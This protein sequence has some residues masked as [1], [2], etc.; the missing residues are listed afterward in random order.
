MNKLWYD[1]PLPFL[2]PAD[3]MQYLADSPYF[4]GYPSK[5]RDQMYEFSTT[6]KHL[7]KPRAMVCSFPVTDNQIDFGDWKYAMPP[8]K[9]Q[10]QEISFLVVALA[11][12]LEGYVE[13]L[14]KQNSWHAAMLD[15][16]AWQGLMEAATKLELEMI[17]Y[18]SPSTYLQL[19][20]HLDWAE[21]FIATYQKELS[22][23]MKT[24]LIEVTDESPRYTFWG[25]MGWAL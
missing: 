7:L 19:T 24:H 11:N 25:T 3:A 14:S 8:G 23:S 21:D 20:K 2:A 6:A 12:Q 13:E 10:Y 4:D 1:L 9:I 15:A 17:L 5:A 18:E 16:L 22:V